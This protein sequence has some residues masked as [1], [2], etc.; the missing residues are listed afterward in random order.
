MTTNQT[1]GPTHSASP[2]GPQQP[3][4]PGALDRFFMALRS[5][6]IVRAPGGPLGGVCAGLAQRLGVSPAIVRIVTVITAVFGV[7]VTLYLI[8]W[9]LLPDARG[10]V[11]LERA[12]RRGQ[13]GSI[14]LLIVTAFAI[15]PDGGRH[16]DDGWFAFVSL[17][18]I[19]LTVVF[20]LRATRRSGAA[21]PA[22][23]PAPPAAQGYP[24][25]PTY[26]NAG[27]P[28]HSSQPTAGPQDSPRW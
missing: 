5:A 15:L 4:Q 22:A 21:T 24:T 1:F 8:A 26:P 2:H 16:Q 9:L 14:A 7:G 19:T 17:M 3:T 27:Q 28:G 6:P 10:Q 23:P 11:H 13:G 20:G 18:A 25:Y 12:I